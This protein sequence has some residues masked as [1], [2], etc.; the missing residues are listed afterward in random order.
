MKPSRKCSA[1]VARALAST[2]VPALGLA[3]GLA[4]GLVAFTP[5]KAQA[6]CSIV[7]NVI[8]C[9]GTI[10]GG[11]ANTGPQNVLN[12]DNLTADIDGIGLRMT[13]NNASDVMFTAVLPPFSIDLDPG[14]VRT[15]RTGFNIITDGAI[16]GT[17]TGDITGQTS[18]TI[19]DSA[20]TGTSATNQ[21][22]VLGF[23]AGGDINVTHTG[24]INVTQPDITRNGTSRADV[25]S[26]RFGALRTESESGDISVTNTGAITVTGGERNVTVN[27]L[28]G[29]TAG[30]RAATFINLV[31]ETH[32]IFAQGNGDYTLDQTGDITV[33][34]GGATAQATTDNN[35][36][37]ARAHFSESAGVYLPAFT[38]VNGVSNPNLPRFEDID[39]DIDGNIDVT[40]SNVSATATSNSTGPME[41]IG[42]A[43]AEAGTFTNDE[44]FGVAVGRNTALTG[45]SV[46][47][48]IDGDVTVTGGAAAATA[49]ASVGGMGETAG[50]ADA[51]ADGQ[52]VTGVILFSETTG[53]SILNISGDVNVTGGNATAV[54]TG[55]ANGEIL[56]NSLY[57]DL[58]NFDSNPT[59]IAFG[60]LADGVLGRVGNGSSVT[61][62]GTVNVKGGDAS[63]S[64]TGTGEDVI[65]SAIGAQSLGVGLS[66]QGGIPNESFTFDTDINITGAS[67]EATGDGANVGV[68]AQGRAGTGLS[69]SHLGDNTFIYEGDI[70]VT[71]GDATGNAMN[72]AEIRSVNGSTGLGINHGTFAQGITGTLIN[73]GTVT[74]TGGDAI[75]NGPLED[76][77]SRSAGGSAYGINTDSILD[78]STARVI[79]EG[80]INAT[81]GNGP[82]TRGIAVGILAGD[83]FADFGPGEVRTE[84]VVKGTI[85]TDGDSLEP[86]SG[87]IFGLSGG[88]V[89][90]TL[91]TSS[92]TVD[93]GTINTMG[94]GSNGIG[95]MARESTV[96]IINGGVVT[97]T[98]ADGAGI[99]IFSQFTNDYSSG[100]PFESAT[101]IVVIDAT[102][103]VTSTNFVGILDAG[104]NSLGNFGG[105]RSMPNPE[106]F[107][108]EA[109]QTTVDLAGTVTGGNG[110][111]ID[112]STGE[113]RVIIRS[114]GVANGDVLLGDGDD[115]FAFEDG[116]TVNG[117][118]DGGDD[119]D[120]IEADIAMGDTRNFDLQ[121]LGLQ[122]FEIIEKTGDGTLNITGAVISD[123]LLLQANE[124]ISQ[125]LSDQDNLSAD[126]AAG[127]T[128]ISGTSLFNVTNGGTLGIGAG[129]IG[130]IGTLDV[131]GDLVF[132]TTGTVIVDIQAPNMGDRIVVS[133]AATLGGTVQVNALGMIDT[134]EA[135]QDYL[136]IEN[137]TSVNGTFAAINDNIPDLDVTARVEDAAG[138][139]NVILSLTAGDPSDKSIYPN[140]LQAAG[141]TSRLFAETL[142]RR[143]ML[144][145]LTGQPEG[146]LNDSN[147]LTGESAVSTFG[148][149][150]PVYSAWAGVFGAHVDVDTSSIATGYDAD[151]AGFAM[152]G[153]GYFE[154]EG[155]SYV[156]T[157]AAFGFSQNDVGSGLSSSTAE[158]WHA[159]L[160]ASIEHGF[161]LASAAAAYSHGD[162]DFTRGIPVAGAAPLVATGNSDGDTFAVSLAASYDIAQQLGLNT[163][164][165][166]RVAPI[167]R[168]DHVSADFNGFTEK[169]AGILNQTV[170]GAG[171]DRSWAGAGIQVSAAFETDGGAVVKP[172][173]ELRFDHAFG[174]DNAHVASR[175]PGV[176][177]AAF[178]SAGAIEGDDALALGAGVKIEFN[179][180]TSAHIR[181]D[182]AFSGDSNSH[183]ASGGIT[184]TF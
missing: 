165:G 128:L 64:F 127:A 180:T 103:S 163:S 36:A 26:G 159:G 81:A 49:N 129:V 132:E 146:P 161:L 1:F 82:D 155:G 112:L 27:N 58:P 113:D 47:V 153:E 2:S 38:S 61:I 60:G 124:G 31:S 63:A 86:S 57:S 110:T 125:V 23:D 179:Q 28:T 178:N 121:P 43:I 116:F 39:I 143:A 142:Q 71:G 184:I 80:T 168:F 32:G 66:F 90:Q 135:D 169:G 176:A 183:R 42:T 87:V 51:D 162:Y 3:S 118:L 109:N 96:D 48:N 11:F 22:G 4:S 154:T 98:G 137:A 14:D 115:R 44:L 170:D 149:A 69:I 181:Y 130:D 68:A 20:S 94:T 140:T 79:H 74:V 84:V 88:V 50:R 145:A 76:G 144:G 13:N 160:Y 117:T 35:I 29:G 107:V 77:T 182:G 123:S 172:E 33:N 148:T 52:T 174:D 62:G 114:T 5:E 78:N 152:G 93:G 131:G 173:L 108:D 157:G 92:V 147:G 21:F 24:I 55:G 138:R 59:T 56:F 91:D 45:T 10:A 65:V 101:S 119:T 100:D 150:A 158:M 17:I 151:V 70:S 85:N 95:I 156:R 12:V 111:A 75:A 122:N 120:I 126:V 134:F 139:Q 104:T 53:P 166:L 72:G 67:G 164:N 97:A 41:N 54:A 106:V 133:G 141:H 83:E 105:T 25:G 89:I 8:D 102:S 99:E 175:I 46:S 40:G 9:T 6:A 16:S 167:I 7:G 73:R 136:F 37:D 30:A 171:W 19:N 34:A 15:Q 18:A 177:G